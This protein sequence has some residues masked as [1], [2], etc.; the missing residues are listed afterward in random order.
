M[1]LK[2]RFLSEQM[3]FWKKIYFALALCSVVFLIINLL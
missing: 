1:R 3:P 2:S